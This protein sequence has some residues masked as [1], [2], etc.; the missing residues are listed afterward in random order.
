MGQ[1][2][3]RVLITTSKD[4]AEQSR[5]FAKL[6]RHVL[7]NTLLINRGNYSIAELHVKSMEELCDYV[8]MITSKED[9]VNHLWIYK[10]YA[11]KLQEEGPV[12]KFNQYIDHKIY[13]FASLPEHGPLSTSLITRSQSPELIDYF[14]QYWFLE[15]GKKNPLW[16]AIDTAEHR[17][18]TYV[19]LIDAL[20]QRKFFYAE[21]QLLDREQL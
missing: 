13:G 2:W 5:T 9:R 6:L 10:I 21:L 8:Y 11:D 14:Q 15:L 17:R 18:T 12:L 1:E 20:T 7:P 19:S 16:L 3:P 4:P